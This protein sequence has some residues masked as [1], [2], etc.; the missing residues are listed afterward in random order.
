M[1]KRVSENQ[2]R[3]Q[4]LYCERTDEEVPLIQ[5][6]FK[7]EHHFICNQHLPLL[8]HNPKELACKL[9]DMEQVGAARGH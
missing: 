8:L 9:P 6:V 5:F 2:D 4:C 3:I 7:G 1:E